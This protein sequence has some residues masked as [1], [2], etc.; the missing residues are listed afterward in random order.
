MKKYLISLRD[1][2]SNGYKTI[3]EGGVL[4]VVR[5][6]LVVLKDTRKENF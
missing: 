2:D 5:G 1:F 6:A 4:K 3:L